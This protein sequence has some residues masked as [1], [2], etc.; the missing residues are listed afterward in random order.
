MFMPVLLYTRSA[1]ICFKSPMLYK[2]TFRQWKA[3][4]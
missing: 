2:T 3:S 4:A 1:K